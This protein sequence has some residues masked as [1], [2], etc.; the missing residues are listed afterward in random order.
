M[1]DVKQLSIL[2]PTLSERVPEPLMTLLGELER[3]AKGLPVEVLGLWDNRAW[4]VG[5]KRNA[6]VRAARGLYLAFVDDDDWVAPD[7][8]SS[9]LEASQ[10]RPE[11]VVFDHV[12]TVDGGLPRRCV[13]GVNLNPDPETWQG[14]P[15]HTHAWAEWIPRKHAYADV[16]VGEDARWAR[17]ASREIKRE[18]RIERVL[19]FY[20]YSSTG[21]LTR[22]RPP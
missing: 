3:Q 1:S 7:Y 17:D 19:Y 15:C 2:V 13:Y 6:M 5:E 8:V 14:L 12:A 20:R 16:N 11:V 4:S 21:S 10:S 22:N 9:I 18:A